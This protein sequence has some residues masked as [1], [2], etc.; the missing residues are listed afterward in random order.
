MDCSINLG[1]FVVKANLYVTILGYYDI[2]I[3]M[4]YLE[5]NDVILNYKLKRL[6]LTDDFEH[7]RVYEETRECP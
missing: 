6:S 7:S 4:E 5:S 2:V 3:G 1:D